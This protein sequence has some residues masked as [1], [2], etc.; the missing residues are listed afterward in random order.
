MNIT[1]KQYKMQIVRTYLFALLS[2]TL[3]TSC[4]NIDAYTE[5]KTFAGLFATSLF[6]MGVLYFIL[7][8]ADR[9][10]LE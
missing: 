9:N 5:C 2:V 10:E 3:F 1:T 7:S 6:V 8:T 4:S